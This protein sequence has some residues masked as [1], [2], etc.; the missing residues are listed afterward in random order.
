MSR[1]MWRSLL[2]MD[3]DANP[4]TEPRRILG[5][6]LNASQL[7]DVLQTTRSM[8]A[9]AKIAMLTGFL[10]FVLELAQQ[11]FQTMVEGREVLSTEPTEAEDKDDTIMMQTAM[12]K[13]HPED[14]L[15]RIQT[16]KWQQALRRCFTLLQGALQLHPQRCGP[17]A[18][19]LRSRLERRYLG[20]LPV[21][22]W[23]EEQQQGHA[24]LVGLCD[25]IDVQ[26]NLTG[27]LEDQEFLRHGGNK[28]IVAS[29]WRTL[30][31]SISCTPP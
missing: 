6:P 7:R 1:V 3:T 10:R 8:Q 12:H 27:C 18:N 30:W 16:E 9:D 15:R 4:G 14:A 23:T 29:C 31:V 5:A 28:Y 11:V 24:M 22:Q 26:E 19:V 2:H 13:E 17:R 21:E 20:F 25:D